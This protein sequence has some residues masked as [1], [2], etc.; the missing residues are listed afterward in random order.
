VFANGDVSVARA[1]LP[2][3]T[4]SEPVTAKVLVIGWGFLGAAVGRRLLADGRSVTGLT[5]SR[6]WRTEAGTH[7]GA[8]IIVGD[9]GDTELLNDALRDIEHVVFALG[10]HSPPTAAAQPSVAAMAMLL[11]LVAVTE[12]L[13]GRPRVGLTYMSSGG[14]VYGNPAR[15]PVREEDPARPISPYGASHLAAETFAEMAAR[16]SGSMLQILRCSNVYGP[17]QAHGGDQ[18]AVAIFLHRIN[19]GESI[20]IFGDGSALRDYVFVEDVAGVVSRLVI[21]RIDTGTVNVASGIGMSVLD[22]A[23]TIS[24]AVGKEAI[25]D[26]QPERSFDVRDIVLD[27]SRLQSF[28]PYV[29]TD[30]ATGLAATAA[31]YAEGIPQASPNR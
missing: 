10:G 14:A 1:I 3:M 22:V 6:T 2:A 21:D 5:R 24:D 29:P 12:A 13:R 15:L 17:H 8:H 25:I 4:G 20:K 9:A 27:I 16:R 19:R 23:I 11:P 18:G 31:A 7:A 26:H 28:L 30:F